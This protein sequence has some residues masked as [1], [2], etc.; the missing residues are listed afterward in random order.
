SDLGCAVCPDGSLKDALEIDW[1]FNKDDNT[2]FTV[3]AKSLEYGS[4]QTL[5]PFFLGQAS[6][7]IIVAGSRRSSCAIRPSNHVV[8]PDNVM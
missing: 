3:A 1:H 4:S 6:P 5:H 7:A 2:P 8:D